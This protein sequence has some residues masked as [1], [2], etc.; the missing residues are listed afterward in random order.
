MSLVVA[1]PL[2]MG[3]GFVLSLGLS[4]AGPLVAAPAIWKEKR[5]HRVTWTGGQAPDD[6]EAEVVWD[7]IVR[8]GL[9]TYGEVTCHV[10][11]RIFRSDH[12]RAGWTGDIGFFHSWYLLHACHMLERLEGRLVHIDTA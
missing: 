2:I 11:D 12:D 1:M 6:E 3:A 4:L 8:R 10:A 9:S 7:A 5:A